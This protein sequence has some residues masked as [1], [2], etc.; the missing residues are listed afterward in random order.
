[1]I[2]LE[3]RKAKKIPSVTS[4]F[5]PLTE[6]N[7]QLFD[8]VIQMQGTVFHKAE[9][10]I[11]IPAN[12]LMFT[13][14]TL[15]KFD[16]VKF[17][18]LK[19]KRQSEKTCKGHVFK[20]TP[21]KHQLEAIDYGLNHGG[22]LLLDD[23]G[24]GKT[25]SMIYLAEMLKEQEGITHC[26][27][28]CGVNS[29]KYNWANEIKKYSDLPCRILGQKISRTGKSSFATVAERCAELKR[30]IKE[31]F[32]VTNL[33]T[34]QNKEFAD[35]FNKSKDTYGM[36][37]VD[38]SHRAKNPTSKSVKTLLK[39]KSPHC[40]ALTGTMIMNVPENAF[41]SLKWTGNTNS[42]FT[43]FKQMFNVYGGFG[44]VQVIGYKNLEVLKDLISSCGLRRLKSDVLDLP[45]K[46][47][48]KEYVEMGKQ[49]R[50]FYESVESG[51]TEEM[52]LL[53]HVPTIM[54]EITINM[55]LRQIT[56]SPSILSSEVT[57]SAKLDRLEELVAD[58]VGQGDKIVV[59]CT[60]KD[61]VYEVC[62]RLSEY[63]ALPCT[64]S[65]TDDEIAVNRNK[66]DTD[67]NCKVL[68]C[69]WQKM[70]T[71]HTIT[72][73]NYAIF[74]DTPY[75]SAAFE[76]ACDR[77]YR[78]GQKKPAFIITLITK[79]T[80]D[81]RVQQIIDTKQELGDVIIDNGKVKTL[82][83]LEE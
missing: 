57:Q 28:I 54:E 30:G 5:L 61:T 53:D 58:I 35:S 29:L 6:Y 79:D 24:L 80:Y 73:A 26:L 44:G 48:I 12:K 83:I 67:P 82:N 32:V 38:E 45:P 39:L 77:I 41:V 23:T 43:Q 64:G 3:E 8:M 65:E 60:F 22:W 47:Y 49:Q 31:F 37:V 17:I 10:E 1:M 16:D 14:K 18:P 40:I 66:F 42:T 50:D 36:I 51:V 46:T 25:L 13:V 4:I 20:V 71:G 59:F 21:Y 27:I 75:T 11:E 72:V 76:Q 68:V 2:V 34:L 33:E 62:R 55:R 74:V 81:E 7:P 78:I 63:G 69:T 52:N 70:G 56:A 19:E 9:R 15:R